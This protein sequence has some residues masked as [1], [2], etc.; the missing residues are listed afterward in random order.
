MK[1][2]RYITSKRDTMGGAPCIAGT[3]VPIE[4]ILSLLKQ[5]YALN[6]I[7][8]MYPWVG[9]DKFEGAMDELVKLANDKI[10]QKILQ[11]QATA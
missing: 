11:T 4:V 1:K 3:R 9:R 2:Y 7:E 10:S 8:K 6:K 5:G